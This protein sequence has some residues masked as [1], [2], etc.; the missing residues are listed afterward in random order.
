VIA[1]TIDTRPERRG[2]PIG[3]VFCMRKQWLLAIEQ[4]YGRET[5]YFPRPVCTGTTQK[6]QSLL[7]NTSRSAEEV[8]SEVKSDLRLAP[9][10]ACPVQVPVTN[11]SGFLVLW[12]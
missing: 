12:S 5:V 11:R 8:E 6:F 4:Y 10:A 1:H 2:H 9:S 3:Y 7:P